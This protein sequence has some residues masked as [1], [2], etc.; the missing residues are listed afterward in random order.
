MNDKKITDNPMKSP[1]VQKGQVEPR[2]VM[3]FGEAMKQ[4]VFKDKQIT[5]LSWDKGWFLFLYKEEGLV[6]LSDPDGEV[7]SFTL[8]GIDVLCKDYVEVWVLKSAGYTALLKI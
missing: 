1:S 7:H 8:R 4:V 6:A 2:N 5:R 3:D